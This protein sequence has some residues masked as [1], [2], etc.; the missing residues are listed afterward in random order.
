MLNKAVFNWFGG[1]LTNRFQ[2]P[3]YQGTLPAS[4]TSSKYLVAFLA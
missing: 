2:L 1:P 4:S 3:E